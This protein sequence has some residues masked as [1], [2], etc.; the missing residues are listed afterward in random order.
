M[1]LGI[2]PNIL[3]PQPNSILWG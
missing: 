1:H 2:S 3:K